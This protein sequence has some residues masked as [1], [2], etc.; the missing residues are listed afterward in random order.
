MSRLTALV[1]IFA[2][3]KRTHAHATPRL[4]FFWARDL[5]CS[6]AEKV[7]DGR[8][9]RAA[10]PLDISLAEATV[11]IPLSSGADRGR[12]MAAVENQGSGGNQFF[13]LI[14][15]PPVFYLQR[16]GCRPER[17]RNPLT[18]YAPSSR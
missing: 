4:G 14:S 9:R 3:R 11:V 13:L 18:R 15:W 5:S 6:V 2:D 10:K 12:G 16:S 8:T 7:N 17:S 1:L